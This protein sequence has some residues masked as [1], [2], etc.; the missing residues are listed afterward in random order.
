MPGPRKRTASNKPV[1]SSGGGGNATKYTFDSVVANEGYLAEDF[2][3][4]KLTVYLLGQILEKL[5]KRFS[6][7]ARKTEL[8][9][10]VERTIAELEPAPEDDLGDAAD[11]DEVGGS[12]NEEDDAQPAPDDDDGDDAAVK[13]QV[14]GSANE[15]DD[16]QPADPASNKTLSNDGKKKPRKKRSG[17]RQGGSS[18]KKQKK[19]SNA[20]GRQGGAK[21]TLEDGAP[22]SANKRP[23]LGTQRD[24]KAIAAERETR[25][26]IDKLE[27]EVQS[28]QQEVG[29]KK[30]AR[31]VTF[32]VHHPKDKDE[33]GY[34]FFYAQSARWG[35]PYGFLSNSFDRGTFQ[36]SGV[37]EDRV[38]LSMEQFCQFAKAK[39]FKSAG[40]ILVDDMGDGSSLHAYNV[41]DAVMYQKKPM[42]CGDL[43]RNFIARAKDVPSDGG[44]WYQAWSA[45][46]KEGIEK[47]LLS[48]LRA[49]FESDEVLKGDLLKTGEY[50]LVMAS[51]QDAFCGIGFAARNAYAKRKKWEDKDDRNM[52]GKALM[53]IRAEFRDAA[54]ESSPG[55]DFD[56]LFYG[57]LER[58]FWQKVLR[59]NSE[60]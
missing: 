55:R 44:K 48:G 28:L 19:A 50:E 35:G 14:G 32:A 59:T 13:D 7:K 60:K 18:P 51:P 17:S 8:V 57:K 36:V 58:E 23:R 6:K 53:K 56:R 29:H 47:T 42:A 34:V 49:K 3:P 37:G 20:G 12:S 43:V 41:T 9:T 21:H 24:K 16:A 22:G 10:L 27:T 15:E 40:N 33:K 26:A 52:L 39:T 25:E 46:W 45:Q 5:G 11:K 4:M 2:D 31:H 54:G 38:F 1:K 30:G